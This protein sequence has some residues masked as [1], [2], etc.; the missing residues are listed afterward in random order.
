MSGSG[1]YKIIL[2]GDTGVGKSTF[3]AYASLPICDAAE[4]SSAP[5]ISSPTVGVDFQCIHVSSPH[6]MRLHVWDT[7]GQEIFRSIVPYYFR[8]AAVALVFFD[9]YE[10]QTFN[11]IPNW[12]DG[13]MAMSDNVPAI[14]LVGNKSLA[15]SRGS[16]DIISS[17]VSDE[18]IKLMA[19][20]Y[21]AEYMIVSIRE[22]PSDARILINKVVDTIIDH[23]L[24]PIHAIPDRLLESE[25]EF[26]TAKTC[27]Q[28]L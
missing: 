11:S 20:H 24:S 1:I 9:V 7:A 28:I 23:K 25:S 6:A 13:L 10:E 19:S 12:L 5:A 8:A 15:P 2:I 3:L 18:R 17:R 14:L 21:N 4:A 22:S 27:C 16:A 26:A